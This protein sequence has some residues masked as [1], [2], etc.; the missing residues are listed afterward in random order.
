MT[1]ERLIKLILTY[2]PKADVKLLERA[3]QVANMAHEGQ[4]RRSGEPFII[5]PLWVAYILAELKLDTDT[6]IAG[7]LHDILEDTQFPPARIKEEFGEEVFLLIEGVSKI[8]KLTHPHKI[9]QQAENLRK[10]LLA[11]AKDIRVILIKLADRLHNMR[12]IRFLPN[13]EIVAKE[14]Q[15]I[16]APLANRLGIGRLRWELEDLS[17]ECLN[18]EAYQDIAKKITEKRLDRE[19]YIEKIKKELISKFKESEIEASVEGRPKHF[20]SIYLKMKSQ[21]KPFDGIYDISA[22][23][24]IT[25]K[26]DCYEALGI[27]H[28][29]WTPI[30]G[31]FKDYIANPKTNNY[32]SLHTTVIGTNGRPLEIQIR[33]KEMHTISEEGIAA[34]WQY[35]E[36]GEEGKFDAE[37]NKKLS[38]ARRLIETYQDLTDAKD[39][40]EHFKLDLFADEVFVFTPKGAVKK[41]P[42]GST[43][44]DFAYAVHSE[45]GDH[46]FGAKVAGKIV[47]LDYKLKSGDIVEI[48]TSNRVKPHQDWLRIVRTSKAK[49]RIRQWTRS[50]EET[51]PHRETKVVHLPPFKGVSAP[52]K[53]VSPQ[54]VSSRI[55]KSL[56]CAL[57][58][59]KIKIAGVN[60]LEVSFSKCCHPV[61]GDK[62]VGYITRG[63]GV[64]IHRVTCPNIHSESF[65]SAHMIDVAW[66]TGKTGVDEVR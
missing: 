45:I 10:M 5:H 50:E 55:H 21:N 63:H 58:P 25:N 32:Q 28:S 47:P 19:A 34:H 4:L 11:M 53:E 48:I 60:G 6:I 18:P 22:V 29:L 1:F 13:R 59:A 42:L 35:K 27:V 8:K 12:T 56:P 52:P 49:S 33:N 26:K 20:Y 37:L 24:I 66:D 30:P 2:N 3:Y 7:L 57:V 9:T 44:I 43:P 41:L 38:W 23:R 46:C 16:Y 64:S 14:T 36:N 31:R 17:F 54:K 51:L 62:I 39:F 15:E 65:D 40:M 61:L